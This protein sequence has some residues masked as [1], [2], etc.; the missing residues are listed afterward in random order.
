MFWSYSVY[1]PNTS[2]FFD[3]RWGTN[4]GY[5]GVFQISYGAD[6]TQVPQTEN[7]DHAARFTFSQSYSSSIYVDQGTVRPNCISIL[8]L[9]RI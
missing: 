1:R 4:L 6:D 2:G 8:V 7:K 9:I 3:L 5:S